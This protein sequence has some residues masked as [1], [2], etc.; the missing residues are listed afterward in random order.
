MNEYGFDDF[1]IPEI[2][3]PGRNSR[4]LLF[5][6][7]LVMLAF[8]ILLNSISMV[9]QKRQ[10][11]SIK[12]LQTKFVAKERAEAPSD[13]VISA[14]KNL[15]EQANPQAN[16]KIEQAN[17]TDFG[18]VEKIARQPLELIKGKITIDHGRLSMLIPI[19][20]FFIKNGSQIQDFQQVFLKRIADQVV[21]YPR[22]DIEFALPN[23]GN[24]PYDGSN[25]AL[26]RGAA[27][28]REMKNLGLD[29][30]EIYAGVR[31]DDTNTLSIA[32]FIR[33]GE[34]TEDIGQ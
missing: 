28:V 7:F 1:F 10:E 5:S 32:F 19:D 4:S 30:S 15:S 34:K 18:E 8:F 25:L 26:A 12:S 24:P 14:Q 16:P 21:R 2:E 3:P 23:A 17:L 29:E 6:I 27:F 13:I 20:A 9:D 22:V 33:S 11:N 31:P